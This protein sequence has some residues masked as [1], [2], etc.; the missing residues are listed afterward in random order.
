MVVSM[1][2]SGE[3]RWV[4]RDL[5]HVYEE[6]ESGELWTDYIELIAKTYSEQESFHSPFWDIRLCAGFPWD[7]RLRGLHHSALYSP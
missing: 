1:R 4:R 6:E 5:E 3:G 2:V 7:G